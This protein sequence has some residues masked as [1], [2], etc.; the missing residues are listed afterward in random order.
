STGL[1]SGFS[2]NF[3]SLP[4]ALASVRRVVNWRIGDAAD[5]EPDQR[6]SVD[7]RFKLDIS[8]LPRPFQIGAIGLSDWTLEAGAIVRIAPAVTAPAS[9]ITPAPAK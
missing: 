1:G 4:E 2:Q 6:L 9:V 8:Q 5:L 3:D 7:F